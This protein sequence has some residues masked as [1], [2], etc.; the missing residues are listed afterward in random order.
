MYSVIEKSIALLNIYLSFHF[1]LS[2]PEPPMGISGVVSFPVW[3][4]GSLIF[5]SFLKSRKLVLN[6]LNHLHWV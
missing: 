1:F 2:S 4:G 6:R 3:S 5:S